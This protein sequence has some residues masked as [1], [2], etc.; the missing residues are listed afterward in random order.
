MKMQDFSKYLPPNTKFAL[1]SGDGLGRIFQGSAGNDVLLGRGGDDALIGDSISTPAAAGLRDILVGGSGND[2]FYFLT[3]PSPDNIDVVMDFGRGEDRIV[4]GGAV[5]L[6][7]TGLT[8]NEDMLAL[9]R[10]PLDA[11]DF[12]I[13]RQKTGALFVD[14]DGN[15]V[16]PTV[17]VAIL[18]NRPDID[19]TDFAF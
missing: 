11:D 14:P 19:H 6:P 16:A 1:V 8:W 13:Y 2:K 5:A 15:G 7:I 18:A 17:Q 4:L 10:R 3:T 12:V 9:A